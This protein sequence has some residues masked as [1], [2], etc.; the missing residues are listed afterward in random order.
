MTIYSINSDE[1]IYKVKGESLTPNPN[2]MFDSFEVYLIID[3]PLKKI[4][5]WA[6]KK[7]RLFQRYVATNW[8]W[9]FKEDIKRYYKHEVIREGQETEEFVE[10]IEKFKDYNPDTKFYIDNLIGEIEKQV[11][12][13]QDIKTNRRV[14]YIPDEIVKTISSFEKERILS[15]LNEVSEIQNHIKS[16]IE[17]IDRRLVSIYRIFDK[18]DD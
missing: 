6:G 9:K 7:S 16:S 15:I 18:K 2:D 10:A 12:S 14:T 8:A 3:N 11:F 5:I 17:H 1:S 13:P 4:W